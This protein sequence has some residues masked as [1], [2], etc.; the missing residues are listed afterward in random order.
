MEGNFL[1]PEASRPVGICWPEGDFLGRAL[2]LALLTV[3]LDGCP[4]LG[5]SAQS[6]VPVGKRGGHTPGT[7][8]AGPS[9]GSWGLPTFIPEVRK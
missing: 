2:F 6:S 1:A 9:S 7:H 8:A 5:G 4:E 3:P